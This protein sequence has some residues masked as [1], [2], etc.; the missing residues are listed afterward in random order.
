[1]KASFC[2]FLMLVMTAC[3][4]KM[5]DMT[6]ETGSEMGYSMNFFRN[7]LAKSSADANVA[8]SPYSAGVALSML[9]EGAE[10]Q[11][12]TEI[13]NALNGC[14]FRNT[15]LG[16]GDS[17][18]VKS[19][20]SV[21]LDD[22][23]AVRNTY[24]ST[25]SKEYDALATTLSFADPETVRAINNWC[26]EHTEGMING[27]IKEL[28]PEMVMVLVNALYFKTPWLDPFEPRAT[29]EDV[30][31]G[32]KGSTT[33]PFMSKRMTCDYFEHDDNK[34]IRIPYEGGRYSMYVLLPSEKVGVSGIV[35]YMTENGLKEL[36]SQMSPQTVRLSLPKF[37]VEHEMS[38]VPVLQSMG[39]TSAFSAAADLS[40]IA[41]GPLCVSDV[42]QKAVV[43]VD[44][45]GSE[46]AAVTAVIVKM[47][48]IRVEN[49][50][51]M[52]VDRPFYYMIADVDAGRVLFAGRVMNL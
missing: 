42:L 40:G 52:K 17:V 13:D 30:F 34:V 19:A 51:E 25:L 26:S 15:D 45:S 23:F 1:M 35:P 28:T 18:T 46:A 8:V 5:T 49:V 9:M 43:D 10:G 4:P 12:R 22:D 50:Q 2:F 16:G 29:R 20:N 48:S 24:V 33:V 27:I 3:S 36:L 7:V 47:T 32:S 41:R 38:L 11:T 39:I 6:F 31:N 37:K 14:L 44:E 21:W